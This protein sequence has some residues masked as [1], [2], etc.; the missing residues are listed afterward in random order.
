MENFEFQLN[1][2]PL[3]NIDEASIQKQAKQIADSFKGFDLDVKLNAVKG[4]SDLRKAL[5]NIKGVDIDVALQG[6]EGIEELR[7]SLS[8]IKDLDIDVA[9]DGKE[10]VEELKKSLSQLKSIDLDVALS[11]EEG[12]ETLKKTLSGI[13]DLDID[14]ALSGDESI[15]AFKKSVESITDID[16]DAALNVDTRGMEQQIDEVDRLLDE[17][18]NDVDSSGLEKALDDALSKVDTGQLDKV[19]EDLQKLG[20]TDIGDSYKELVGDYNKA[21]KEAKEFYDQQVAIQA[22]MKK[23]GQDGSEEYRRIAQSVDDAEKELREFEKVENEIFGSG[24]GGGINKFVNGMAKFGLVSQGIEQVTQSF[25]RFIGPY[26]EFDAQI[27]NVGTLGVKNLDDIRNS[28]SKLAVDLPDSMAGVTEAIY[29]AVSASAI[30]VKDGIADMAAGMDFIKTSAK[31]SVAGLTDTNSAVQLLA[32]TVNA[33]G[34]ENLDTARAADTL[35]ATVKNGVTT[36]PELVASMSNITPIASAAGVEI[37]EVG[38]SIATLTA[39]GT[40]TAQ[41]STQIAAAIGE[42]IK[43]GAQLKKVMDEAGVSVESLRNEG[44]VATMDRLSDG[45]Q[46]LGVD[47]ANTFSS[48]ESIKFA[49]STTG[50]ANLSGFQ[51]TLENIKAGAGSV[52]EAFAVANE[53]IGVKVQGILNQVEAFAFKAFDTIGQGAVVALDAASNLAPIATTF[54]SLS[55]VI[56]DGTFAKLKNFS[57]S[58]GDIGTKFDGLAQKSPVLSKQLTGLAGKM[59]SLGGQ[60]SKLG[61]AM[62]NPWVLGTTAAV[63]GLGLFF[64]K[65]EK[66]QKILA[67]LQDK[68]EAFLKS[69]EPL[70]GQLQNVGSEVVDVLVTLGELAFEVLI[71]PF[72][73]AGSAIGGIISL[74]GELTGVQTGNIDTM[75]LFSEI[76]GFVATQ[77]GN[78]G[79]GI[80]LFILG[81]KIAKEAVIGFMDGLPELIGAGIDYITHKLNPANWIGGEESDA[82]L[83][84]IEDR[85]SGAISK[86]AGNV[87][88][89]I[90]ENK[91]EYNLDKALEVKGELNADINTQKLLEQYKNATDLIEKNEIAEKIKDQLPEVA[92]GYEKIVDEAGNVVEVANINVDKADELLKKQIQ[93]NEANIAGNKAATL[94]ALSSQ[95]AAF[96]DLKA[97]AAATLDEIIA[98]QKAGEDTSGLLAQFEEQKE[99]ILSE[100]E[101][102]SNYLET[103]GAIGLDIRDVKFPE[104]FE[105]EFEGELNKLRGIADE[106]DISEVFSDI[107]KIQFQID[108]NNGIDRLVQAYQNA[109]D[110]VEKSRLAEKIQRALPDDEAAKDAVKAV[111]TVID[112]TG[113]LVKVYDLNADKVKELG[114]A[115]GDALGSDLSNKV[116]EFSSR[117]VELGGV[118]AENAQ[119]QKEYREEIQAAIEAGQDTSDLEA[120][121]SAIGKGMEETQSQF[122]T[123]INKA[124]AAGVD[125][126]D[127]YQELGDAIGKSADEVR[128]MAKAQA[129]SLDISEEQVE[130]VNELAEQWNAA[131]KGVTD[132]VGQQTAALSELQSRINEA[133]D[134]ETRKELLAQRDELIKTTREHVKEMKNQEAID[135]QI[136]IITGQKEVKGKSLFE[137]AKEEYGQKEKQI[138]A[139]RTLADIEYER[140]L[141]ADG[142]EKGRFDELV[143]AGK[144]IDSLNKQ[145]DALQEILEKRKLITVA[146]DG[147]IEYKTRLKPAEKAELEENFQNLNNQILS[148]QNEIE[149]IR[150]DILVDEKQIQDELKA[151]ELEKIENEIEVGLRDVT[152][153]DLIVDV[154]REKSNLLLLEQEQLNNRLEE[155]DKQKNK[156]IK[157]AGENASAEEKRAIENRFNAL[158]VAI[159]K[160][161]LE[162]QKEYEASEEKITDI[163]YA[164][165][166]FRMQDLRNFNEREL[167]IIKEKG[168][169][170][171]AEFERVNSVIS[172]VAKNAADSEKNSRLESLDESQEEY[173]KRL[174]NYKELEVITEKTYEKRK[175]EIAEEYAKKKEKLEEEY[176]KKEALRAAVAGGNRAFIEI[177]N[178]KKIL[179]AKLQGQE[180]E[181]ETTVDVLK[182]QNGLT[183]DQLSELRKKYEEHFKAKRELEEDDGGNKEETQRLREQVDETANILAQYNKN[184]GDSRLDAEQLNLFGGLVEEIEG[185]TNDLYNKGNEMKAASDLLSE[186]I[187][188]SIQ[189]WGAGAD[190][191]SI[192]DI[193]RQGLGE[194]AGYLQKQAEGMVLNLILSPGV[195]A[196][197]NNIPFPGNV[198]AMAIA[199]QVISSAVKGLTDPIISSILSFSEGGSLQGAYEQPTML[200]VGDGIKSGNPYDREWV[201]NDRNIR[202]IV[203]LVA[204]GFAQEMVGAVNSLRGDIKGLRLSTGIAGR[205]IKVVLAQE[206]QSVD[207]RSRL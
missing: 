88:N 60:F 68:G 107:G 115:Q 175:L 177:E 19:A 98:K 23:A 184:L 77:I 192:K 134:P 174:E 163:L 190:F 18:F 149:K 40:P 83:K 193:W 130:S 109:S 156:A 27:Q 93:I 105:K 67:D 2:N 78:V 82:E 73:L 76:L 187:T 12:I 22:A 195:Q 200:K 46:A 56:P 172:I 92:D 117:V 206:Q 113:K 6:E 118:Y 146:D 81:F 99:A 32:G 52:E 140:Q 147:T 108:E 63:A 180:E 43:P 74:I 85:M 104:G 158:V 176:R 171:I 154:Y 69:I 14:V 97:N 57:S 45:M 132:L 39:K 106:A 198:A 189:S 94:E 75:T 161:Q 165:Y 170:E 114:K 144:E 89:T 26:K 138:G 179:T 205:D 61:P 87:E 123:Y 191:E 139:E 116:T 47:A 159:K 126:T 91:I 79:N 21:K 142:R 80:E 185:T 66:G 103:A 111:G 181:I 95:S 167:D 4:I 196:Y 31:L 64:T 102:L 53:G 120:K 84:A 202:E 20:N 188:D 35:F 48:V 5:Q 183:D 33:Y 55:T 166:E 10:G 36:I 16:I 199:Q 125:T 152:D 197:L 203:S 65:T 71:T 62:L 112:E 50:E 133:N 28:A 7:K 128:E 182:K 153:Y 17:L 30:P 131:K 58:L 129:E 136:L 29:N 8:Q 49:F 1:F 194:V 15:E 121:Y 164:Q 11:G 151:I 119:K 204:G 148:N 37:E 173:L 59:T 25:D 155:L 143:L 122:L 168:D 137:L 110:E 24:G 101:K 162:K 145:R 127:L 124:E 135:E 41:A 100:R 150:L 42:L 96:A 86:I 207:R 186:S 201:F 90:N 160:E 51:N 9:L 54:A 44:L 141:L 13:N 3:F 178:N 34:K 70:L 38:A 72:E 157:D 169:A